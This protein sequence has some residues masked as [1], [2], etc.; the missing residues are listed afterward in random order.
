MEKKDKEYEVAAFRF[1]LIAEFVTGVRL[2]PGEKERLLRERSSRTYQIPHSSLTR[3]SRS[4]LMRWITDYKRA[5][6]RIEGLIP[7]SRKDR[8]TF[9]TLDGS[10]QLAIKEI[11]EQDT[12]NKL[13]GIAIVKELRQRKYIGPSDKINLSVL[14]RFLKKNNLNKTK[15]V[16]DRR[17]YE[18]EYPNELW[19]SDVLHGP[20]VLGGKKKKKSYLIA[21]ID[22][23]S[24]LIPH[25]EF[26]LS[27]KLVDFKKCLKNAIERR[28]LPQKLYIDNGACYKA[29]NV[30]QVASCLGFSV[31]HT[32]PYTPEGRGKIERWF[33]YVRDNF[34]S[35]LKDDLTLAKLNELF[36]D[37]VDDYHNKVHSSTG[38]TPLIRY[39]QN[40]KCVRP[41]PSDLYD[42]FRFVEF[43]RVKKDRT[44]RLNG[45][46]FEAPVDLV[47]YRVELRFH[48]ESADDVE[49]FYDGK[50][51]GKAVLL[52]KGVNFRV[53][54]NSKVITSEQSSSIAP[55]ELF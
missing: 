23:N 2:A 3:V 18:A 34:L 39:Q 10:L 22:D 15:K 6:S 52:N 40:M 27:E 49:I 1:G 33:R 42:Y 13:T 11:K 14:Y 24:R 51:F 31:V 17:C 30:G 38:Q 54:R 41:V 45:T 55:G 5:G 7:T 47:D 48:Q 37:W 21:I 9:R 8:G 32:P 4:T 44:I 25:A 36:S 28:G 16:V 26:Y 19:Q 29:T 46:L 20:M 50:S 12:Q 35:T 43:R 53:G